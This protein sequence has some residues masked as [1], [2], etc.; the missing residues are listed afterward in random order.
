MFVQLGMTDDSYVMEN[1]ETM[2]YRDFVNSF[3]HHLQI[4]LNKTRLILKI[5]QDDIMWDKLLE[6]NLF[7][8]NKIVGLKNATC[9]NIRKILVING[10]WNPDDKDMI[11]MYHKFGTN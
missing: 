10:P 2:S 6:L 1:S 8:K 7:N 9:S 5:D 11:V 3:C 4:L